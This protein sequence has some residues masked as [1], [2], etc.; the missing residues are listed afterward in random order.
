MPLTFL[1]SLSLFFSS[2]QLIF[3]FENGE[4]AVLEAG[5]RLSPGK[6]L[7]QNEQASHQWPMEG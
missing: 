2:S 5:R 7:H 3:A 1:A 6:S 4:S